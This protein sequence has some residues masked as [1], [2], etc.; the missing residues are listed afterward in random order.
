MGALLVIGNFDGVHRGHRS[1]L[2]SA[3]R[4]GADLGLDVRL[5]TFYPPPLQVLGRKPPPLL[6]RQDRKRELIARV[7]T[8]IG[9]VEQHFDRDYA[10]Q[11]PLDF[12]R[13]LREE[14][15]ARR[16]VVGKNFRFGRDRQGDFDRLV[17]LGAELGFTARFQ[18]LAGDAAG[19]WSSTRVRN[20]VTDGDLADAE[21]VLGRPHMLSGNVVM[22]K[23]LGRTLGFP[24]CNLDDVQEALP[25][26]GVYAVLVDELTDGGARALAKGA[27]N[28]GTNPTTDGD[29]LV[30]VEVYLLDFDGDR[31]GATL[32][33][34]LVE[35]LRSEEKFED[36]ETLTA[37]M[38]MDVEA[39]RRALA[40][41]APDPLTSAYG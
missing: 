14:H 30:K 22:G 26:H 6:T 40:G 5:L 18:E 35:R 23:Q 20:A 34:H 2:E 37:R 39:T 21:R 33:V 17:Q 38:R 11:S 27:M 1:V 28:I 19:P 13:R 32:R 31:Y 24:T 25:P 15:D 9:V 36:L 8:A 41:R 7:S 16:V 12:S 29:S 4:E 3:A 10:N